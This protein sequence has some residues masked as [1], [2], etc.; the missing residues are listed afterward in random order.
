MEEQEMW[1]LFWEIHSGNSRKGPGEFNPQN[2]HL[3]FSKIYP[4]IPG[5][6][7]TVVDLGAQTIDLSLLTNG[8]IITIDNHPQFLEDLDG[9]QL[10]QSGIEILKCREDIPSLSYLGIQ[11]TILASASNELRIVASVD[12]GRSSR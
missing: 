1:E 10:V 4:P 7:T 9:S 3:I 5:S 8:N 12:V 6:W 11:N 2:G